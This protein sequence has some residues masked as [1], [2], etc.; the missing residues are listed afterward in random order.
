MATIPFSG[1]R[2]DQRLITGHGRYTADVN[3]PGQAHAAFVRADRA[4]A[5]IRAIDTTAARGAP[6][7]LAVYTGADTD[8]EEFKTPGVMV[9]YPGRGGM[10]V[11]VPPWLPFARERVRYVGEEIAVVVAESAAAAHDAAGL[12]EV[13]YEDLPAVAHPQDAIKPDAPQV[14]AGVPDNLA[15]DYEYGDE[16]ATAAAFAAAPHTVCLKLDSQRVAPC[17]ME[18]RACVVAYDG[19]AFDLHVPNQGQ[20]M[21]RPPHHARRSPTP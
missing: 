1:R 8:P 19:Q 21:L 15:F 3:L 9:G 17:P 20:A 5:L 2:E 12:I 6:G 7:V 11:I 16:A 10:K 13:D 18:P 4:H 14:H